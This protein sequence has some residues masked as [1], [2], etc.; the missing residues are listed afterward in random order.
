MIPPLCT[1]PQDQEATYRYLTSYLQSHCYLVM[2]IHHGQIHTSL[3]SD[4][5]SAY[6]QFRHYLNLHV[7][8]TELTESQIQDYDGCLY[9]ALSSI[10][11]EQIIHEI[12]LI[13]VEGYRSPRLQIHPDLTDYTIYHFPNTNQWTFQ[14]LTEENLL[15]LPGEYHVMVQQ[16]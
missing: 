12:S 9:L 11:Q 6:H 3:H 15:T 1:S 8:L 4:F 5:E 14:L 10:N 7:P 2:E 13:R 16:S